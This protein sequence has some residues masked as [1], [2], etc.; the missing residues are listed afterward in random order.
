MKIENS[1]GKSM[2]VAGMLLGA[3][4][5]AAGASMASVSD[6]TWGAAWNTSSVVG[7][8]NMTIDSNQKWGTSHTA[9]NARG[10]ATELFDDADNTN[11]DLL[12]TMSTG[13]LWVKMTIA[14]TCQEGKD[15]VL[16]KYSISADSANRAPKKWAIY[17]ATDSSAEWGGAGLVLIDSRDNVAGTTSAEYDC[18]DNAGAY[19]TYFFVFESNNG[20]GLLQITE[21]Y[22]FGQIKDHEEVIV[23]SVSG[24]YNGY[25]NGYEHALM[26]DV[27]YPADGWAVEYSIDY[28]NWSAVPPFCKEVGDYVIYY[29]I[30]ASGFPTVNGSKTIYITEPPQENVDITATVRD[31]ETADGTGYH[32]VTTANA[33]WA[34]G[35]S[36][37][38]FVD[39]DTSQRAYWANNND[40]NT[41]TYE[42]YDDYRPGDEITVKGL[43]FINKKVQSGDTSMGGMKFEYWDVSSGSWVTLC[44]VSSTDW[45]A[46]CD[47]D[48]DSDNSYYSRSYSLSDNTVVARKYR[49][50]M[51]SR[52]FL[53]ELVLTGDIMMFD[54]SKIL[55]VG[56]NYSAD[57]DGE[58]HGIEV[59]VS[60]PAEGYTIY[61][62]LDGEDWTTDNP[63]FL[64]P[65][66]V[67]DVQTVYWKVECD[68]YETASGVNTV[69]IPYTEL[70]ERLRTDGAANGTTYHSLTADGAY[71]ADSQKP[72][73]MIDGNL[74]TRGLY[75]GEALY[76]TISNNWQSGKTIVL[77]SV[78]FLQQ[79][80]SDYS[81]QRLC[82]SFT[83]YGRNSE[84]EEWVLFADVP[85]I[86]WDETEDFY[87]A[88]NSYRKEIVFDNHESFRQYKFV[89]PPQSGTLVQYT[90]VRFYGLVGAEEVKNLLATGTDYEAAYDG[91]KHSI[92][93]TVTRPSSGA[94]VW[95]A[96][97]EEGPWKTEPP[98]TKY[99]CDTFPVYW[100][101]TAD[102]FAEKSGVN[103]VTITE[104]AITDTD[105][106]AAVRAQGTSDSTTYYTVTKTGT[107]SFNQ[108]A[109]SNSDANMVNGQRNDRNG[110]TG[111]DEKNFTYC[112]ADG[113]RT[114]EDIVVKGIAFEGP[115]SNN[116]VIDGEKIVL[117]TNWEL[118]GSNDGENWTKIA[119]QTTEEYAEWGEDDL[120]EDGKYYYRR[121]NFAN[122]VSY[123][124][125]KLV[126]TGGRT[127]ISELYLYGDIGTAHQSRDP[128]FSDGLLIFIR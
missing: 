74:S 105:I 121:S 116:Q 113:F 25:Y 32:D 125:Y 49:L 81:S 99:L 28:V 20:D 87:E 43:T 97:S 34:S 85:S 41:L 5:F 94:T 118:R 106:T 111:N 47:D 44:E 56:S 26:I 72:S 62:S 120:I 92:S 79:N 102:G 52:T 30:T 110:W 96:I 86:T 100:K 55:A 8:S 51:P 68:G 16:K 70:A 22:L 69:A 6:D 35:G 109:T 19:R 127:H 77:K 10:A 36:A 57:Y 38:W 114:G 50:T 65:Y 40:N 15:F 66:A 42:I 84:D 60:N 53:S 45:P 31:A 89:A 83:A 124:Q 12:H 76:Y 48:Y 18:S 91:E 117:P 73:N 13:T 119:G 58:E 67:T 112:I 104:S 71:T 9:D 122:T 128:H 101:V 37:E 123:R 63:M 108:S 27:S 82:K 11:N 7:L 21:L 59:T 3:V 80:N 4:V 14:D 98:T 78:M 64:G 54:D 103:Y 126:I 88:E 95:Y 24:D 61:Y 33:G 17:G 115:S 90:E 1:F 2:K 39:G 23:Y 93:V 107:G 75:N 46:W 29:R